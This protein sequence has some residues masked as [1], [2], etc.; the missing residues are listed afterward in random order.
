M[1]AI[2][3]LAFLLLGALSYSQDN[4]VSYVAN[5][6]SSY[7]GEPK[8][9]YIVGSSLVSGYDIEVRTCST[10]E[11]IIL[12][13]GRRIAG[14]SCIF[15]EKSDYL[16]GNLVFNNDTTTI[17]DIVIIPTEEG[18][19]F[20]VIGKTFNMDFTLITGHILMFEDNFAVFN[21]EG[22]GVWTIYKKA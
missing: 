19:I 11:V 21:T 10:D 2:L 6:N 4:L 12:P 5:K 18:A 3:L 1:K 7:T 22:K 15:L 14:I 16:G 8:V 20:N 13:N 17:V 9:Q